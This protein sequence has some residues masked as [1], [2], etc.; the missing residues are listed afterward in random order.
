M[1]KSSSAIFLWT[2][3]GPTIPRASEPPRVSKPCAPWGGR[4]AGPAPWQHTG[5]QQ[6]TEDSTRNRQPWFTACT[7]PLATSSLLMGMQFPSLHPEDSLD[8]NQETHSIQ[9]GLKFRHIKDTPQVK[10]ELFA[11]QN[12]SRFKHVLW[13]SPEPEL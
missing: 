1:P 6:D 10:Y 3:P 13:H 5:L 12:S 8:P 2:S 9:H 7:Y 4:D 11:V